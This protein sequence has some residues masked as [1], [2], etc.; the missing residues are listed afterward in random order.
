MS[1]GL[2]DRFRFWWI[3]LAPGLSQ[4]LSSLRSCKII[5]ISDLRALFRP[6]TSKD[7]FIAL[8]PLMATSGAHRRKAN[9]HG[10][11]RIGPKSS[12]K[13]RP[14]DSRGRGR[15][16]NFSMAKKHDVKDFRLALGGRKRILWAGQDMPVLQ[17]V[18]ERFRKEK[19]LQGMRFSACLHVT[20]ETANLVQVLKAGGANVVL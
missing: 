12:K 4:K 1:S 19:P 10:K 18:R 5:S 11:R 17:R 9:S 2:R 6:S 7:P 8:P 16:E 14:A 15:E 20:A 3:R 13:Q